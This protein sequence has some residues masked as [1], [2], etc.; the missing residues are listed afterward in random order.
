MIFP[1]ITVVVPV[2][3]VEQYL[4]RCLDSILRQKLKDIEVICINDASTDGSLDILNRYATNDQRIRIINLQTNG[5]VGAARNAGI[6]SARGETICFC[7]PDDFLPDGALEK[8][9]ALYARHKCVVKGRRIDM[10]PEGLV[11][12]MDTY[13]DS[14]TQEPFSPCDD[15][16]NID[17]FDHHTAWLFPTRLLLDNAIEYKEGMRNGQDLFFM[18]KSFFYIDRMICSNE[19]VYCVVHRQGSATNRKFSA[20]NYINILR[21]ADIFYEESHK[22]NKVLIGDCYFNKR[23]LHALTRIVEHSGRDAMPEGEFDRV[24]EYGMYLFKKYGAFSRYRDDLFRQ[25]FQG[26]ELL[27][28]V[29]SENKGS[30]SYRIYK[31]QKNMQIQRN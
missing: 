7:D 12:R 1:V 13:A 26:T 18:A 11:T 25:T 6:R 20:E 27:V 15:Y 4:A 19:P 8:R 23:I 17:L 14:L 16:G 30:A 22:W 21:C 10:T 5:G 3:N 24:I 31:A 9:Y 29:A 2:Y 28:Q